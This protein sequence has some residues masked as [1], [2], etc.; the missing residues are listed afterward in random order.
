MKGEK[1]GN[2]HMSTIAASEKF[3]KFVEIIEAVPDPRL[4]RR[5]KHKFSSI[6]VIIVLGM[7][8]NSNTLVSIV[9]FAIFFKEKLASIIDIRNGIPSRS[10]FMRVLQLI[11]PQGLEFW[12][13]YWEFDKL[14]KF[15]L[16]QIYIDGK[17]DKATGTCSLRALDVNNECVLAHMQIPD[18]T[19]EIIA[20]PML[21]ENINL[22]NKVVTG[23]AM[24]AQKKFARKIIHKS[25]HYIFTLKGNHH[26][27]H[28]DV[29]LCLDNIEQNDFLKGTIS[30]CE[31]NEKSRNRSEKR[32]CV[33]TGNLNWLYNRNRWKGLKSIS[34]II[35]HRTINGVTSKEKR[36]FISSLEPDAQKILSLVRSHWEIENRCH[37]YLDNTF[38]A[39]KST[40]RNRTAALNLSILRDFVLFLLLRDGSKASLREKRLANCR[41]IERPLKMLFF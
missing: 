30:K 26:Q 41:E 19:N 21:I 7:L 24:H 16:G 12:L 2:I 1:M 27:F 38:E 14:A 34:M 17:Q 3:V 6:I 31:T 29:A 8:C 5:K 20:A 25:G 22:V 35:S 23:D 18:K 13:R 15:D 40:T 10:T 9:N 4:D 39:D 32:I 28:E 37:G 11:N 33:S 36:Y